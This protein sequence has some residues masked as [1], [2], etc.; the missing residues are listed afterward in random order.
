MLECSRATNV[1]RQLRISPAIL[2]ATTALAVSLLG[3]LVQY[4]S[5]QQMRQEISAAQMR[6]VKH[7]LARVESDLTLLNIAHSDFA[8]KAG[9]AEEIVRT[10]TASGD[11]SQLIQ[12]Q[13]TLA[14]LQ[15]Q[16]AKT[17]GQIS[18][19]RKRRAELQPN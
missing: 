18:D 4:R 17:S 14:F 10:R 2:I 16:V 5:L 13:L 7:E 15:D 1:P 12:A 3:N 19:L 8:R 9:K 11:R 6:S